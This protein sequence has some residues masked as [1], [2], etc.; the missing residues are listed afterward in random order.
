MSWK[1]SRGAPPFEVGELTAGVRR[2]LASHRQL[3]GL[4]QREL[5]EAMDPPVSAAAV[6]DL[7]NALGNLTIHKAEHWA[8]GLGM[9]MQVS[10]AFVD[11]GE[12]GESD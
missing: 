8:G 11:Q 9:R 1:R 7:E 12:G 5:G 2:L 6:H 10:F 3:L 4:T